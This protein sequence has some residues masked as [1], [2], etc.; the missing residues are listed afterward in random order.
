MTGEL[1]CKDTLNGTACAKC[2]EDQCCAE[3][4]ACLDDPDCKTCFLASGLGDATCAEENAPYSMLA[5]CNFTT[6]SESCA[7]LVCDV[8]AETPS[9]GSCIALQP[10]LECNPV[11]AEPCDVAGGETCGYTQN[12]F[13]CTPPPNDLQ[14]CDA[15]TGGEGSCGPGLACLTSGNCAKLC[16]EDADCGGGGNVCQK[17][18]FA[19]APDLGFCAPIPVT[20]PCDG[21]PNGACDPAKETCQC[22]DCA[23]LALCNPGQ[24]KNDATCDAFDSCTCADCDESPRCTCNYDEKCDTA[25]ESC[26]CPDCWSEAECA[27]NP[28]EKCTDDGTCGNF[29]FCA[30]A[31]CK[32]TGFCQDPNHCTDNG[33]CAPYEGCICADCMAEPGCQ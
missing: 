28:Q 26:K 13:V 15:C 19:P 18:G 22:S 33:T 8:P 21:Q 1:D 11:T 16:C 20:I 27:D 10:G 17:V 31:D 6:C 30:C 25:S 24:C 32:D 2:I 29:E 3:L 9:N 23:A 12:G 14:L 4:T 7:P 5:A